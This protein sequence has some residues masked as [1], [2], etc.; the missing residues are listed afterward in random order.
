[1][2]Q[3]AQISPGR[4]ID[5]EEN[6]AGDINHIDV[7]KVLFEK[8]ARLDGQN[9]MFGN[10]INAAASSG[11]RVMLD[12]MLR[13]FGN[14]S[15]GWKEPKSTILSKALLTAITQAPENHET[16][17]RLLVDNGANIQYETSALLPNL[18]LEAAATKC[19]LGVVNYLLE[20]KDTSG[21]IADT[22]AESGIHGTALRAAIAASKPGKEEVAECLINRIAERWGLKDRSP[23]Q[24]TDPPVNIPTATGELA[25]PTYGPVVVDD[26]TELNW[27][28]RDA[29][30]GN[31]LQLA[32][33]S[34]L[35]N[36]VELLLEYGADPNVRDT[37][38]RTCLHVAA[39]F[40]FPK[41]VKLLLENGADVN[42]KDEWGA[43][44]LDQAE[45]SLDRKGH[46]GA[47]VQDLQKIV[48]LLW[49]RMGVTD[50]EKPGTEFRGPKRAPI[51]AQ[52][53]TRNAKPVFSMPFWI[54]GVG[55]RATIVDIW[56][57]EEQECLLL[58]KPRIEEILYHRAVLDS[59][60]T[61]KE[62]PDG[63]KNKLRWVH[64]PTNNVSE[65]PLS[66]IRKTID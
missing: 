40:G 43:T 10:P 33:V 23:S 48:Q 17:A 49:G 54:P 3:S 66:G 20:T 22:L 15:P 28:Q 38:Q 13:N 7:A 52:V 39:W 36:T 14:C 11:S 9:G 26:R 24:S 53:P 25:S 47:T 45:E 60:M 30:Y 59:I 4:H 62:K 51:V 63:V 34:G 65:L 42:A 64:I 6:D 5:R 12:L 2:K 31:L 8:G 27:T 18:P 35:K 1:L 37:S 46:P 21:R 57:S 61:S 50:N 32:T 44:P 55:F 16:L 19:L 58:K 29:E 41:I 56:E